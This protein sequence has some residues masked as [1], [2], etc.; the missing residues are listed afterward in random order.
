M[1]TLYALTSAGSRETCWAWGSA[2]T[3][4]ALLI[5]FTAA[6]LALLDPGDAA[7]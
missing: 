4:D 5:N 2:G 3:A 1:R 7:G 6:M